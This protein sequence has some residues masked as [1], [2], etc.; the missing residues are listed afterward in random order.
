[1]SLHS[2]QDL[3][4]EQLKNLYDAEKQILDAL[5]RL[6]TA[7]TDPELQ[8]ALEIHR[9]ESQQHVSRLERIFQD[10]GISPVVER[11]R[12]MQALI[13]GNQALL[14]KNL[15]SST[16]D[17]GLIAATQHIA[18]YEMAGYASVYTWATVLGR[19]EDA[20]LLKQTLDEERTTDRNLTRLAKHILS[21]VV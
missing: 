20:E 6:R 21:V 7:T 11:N 12:T 4:V 10:L 17:T 16:K 2:L 3:Y 1:M 19:I 8:K 18:H 15:E 13:A 14:E 5:P 9:R